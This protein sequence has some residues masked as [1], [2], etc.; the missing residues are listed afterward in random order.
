MPDENNEG[1]LMDLS[2]GKL[3]CPVNDSATNNALVN[4]EKSKDG[5]IKNGQKWLVGKKNKDGWFL[6]TNCISKRVL[7]A[8]SAISTTITGT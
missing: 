8:T 6:I 4:L 7:T 1:K 5:L 3:L 2:S